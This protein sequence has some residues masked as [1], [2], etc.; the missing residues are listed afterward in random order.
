MSSRRLAIRQRI[1]TVENIQ[2][3]TRTL[4]TV[5]A[6]R[7]SRTR[8][9]A[10]GLCEYSPA[11]REM[12]ERQ[13]TRLTSDSHIEDA[14]LLRPR[15]PVRRVALVVITADRGMCGAY[16][17]EACRL[18]SAHGENLL[19]A[20]QEPRFVVIGRKGAAYLARRRAPVVHGERWPRRGPG[21]PEVD[22]LLD[23]LVRLYRS[24]DV[25]AVDVV[26]TEFE[27]VL[28]H[29]ARVSRLMPLPALPSAEPA[30]ERRLRWAYEPS[31][32]VVFDGLV[33]RV[34]RVHLH[35]ML[36]QSHASEHAARMV[37]MEEATERAERGLR[38]HRVQYHRLRREGITLDLIGSLVA[39]RMRTRIRTGKSH[40]E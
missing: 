19:R 26:F 1:H 18:A 23:L 37:T 30:G 3:V 7:L 31:A 17:L 34:L 25:D 5:A 28:Y 27:S 36:L 21:A 15:E 14:D 13:R 22:Q 2:R 12:L 29:R 40:H 11:L 24:G 32:G 6:A 33:M 10:A 8:R 35:A 39:S 38:D 20:G 9:R 4:A 16:N